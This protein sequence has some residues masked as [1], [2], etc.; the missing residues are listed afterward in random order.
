VHADSLDELAHGA[1]AVPNGVEDAAASRFGDH[2]E[3]GELTGHH[4]NIR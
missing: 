4:T 3:Y 2:I 1:L